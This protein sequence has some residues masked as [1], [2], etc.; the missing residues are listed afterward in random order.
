M[1]VAR[2]G[3]LAP[4]VPVAVCAVPGPLHT[5]LRSYK[6]APDARCRQRLTGQLG[7]ILA[8]FVDEHRR[9]LEGLGAT[10]LTRS[11]LVPPRPGRAPPWPMSAVAEPSLEAG[12]PPVMAAL[13]W[14]VDAATSHLV[15]SS[16]AF[17]VRQEARRTLRGR[18]VVLLDDSYTTGATAQSAA[19]RL[20][21]AGAAAVVVLVLGR[22]V[23]PHAS[24]AQRAY[25][26]AVRRRPPAGRSGRP[27][28]CAAGPGCRWA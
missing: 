25:W 10:P 11:A 26:E 14:R 6:D 3:S 2:L 22:V 4:V 15:A 5:M 19:L 21:A 9:C 28:V 12:L 18:G 8:G 13:E 27:P 16:D 7:A 1:L 20:R 23:R 17:T 24:P